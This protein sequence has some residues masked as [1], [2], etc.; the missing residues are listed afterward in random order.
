MNNGKICFKLFIATV[1]VIL[2]PTML[3]RN[4][5]T[6]NGQDLS[7]GNGRNGRTERKL[8]I[9]NSLTCSLDH[10]HM[11]YEL[12]NILSSEV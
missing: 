12:C 2:F 11:W 7:L 4:V 10:K 9:C 1:H 6:M 8:I 5:L 3:T